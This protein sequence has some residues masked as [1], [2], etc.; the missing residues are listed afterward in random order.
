MIE[1][2]SSSQ[3]CLKTSLTE[4]AWFKGIRPL[5]DKQDTHGHRIDPS[6]THTH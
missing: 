4:A 3:K 1:F 2:L 5:V 6:F